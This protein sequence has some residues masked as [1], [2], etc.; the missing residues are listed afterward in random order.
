MA[1]GTINWTSSK[2]HLC[3]LQSLYLCQTICW[4]QLLIWHLSQSVEVTIEGENSY[5]QVYDQATKKAAV[6]S[7]PSSDIF[8]NVLLLQCIYFF[9]VLKVLSCKP[10]TCLLRVTPSYFCFILSILLSKI[11][12]SKDFSQSFF[13]FVYKKATDFCEWILYHAALMKVF[14]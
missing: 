11:S 12:F 14:I 6:R 3:G 1:S 10:F 2:A 7:F 8:F 9:N 5:F 4:A 13:L